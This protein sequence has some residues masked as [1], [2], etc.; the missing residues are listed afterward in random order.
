MKQNTEL[1]ITVIGMAVLLTIAI[2]V[3]ANDVG[4]IL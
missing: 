2:M 3:T 1:T 4:R